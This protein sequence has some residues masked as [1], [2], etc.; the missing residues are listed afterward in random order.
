[1]VPIFT[2]ARF[3]TTF[4][5]FFTTLSINDVSRNDEGNITCVGQEQNITISLEGTFYYF[6]NIYLKGWKVSQALVSSSNSYRLP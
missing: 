1:M 6:A 3:Q 4:F 5:G 2:G